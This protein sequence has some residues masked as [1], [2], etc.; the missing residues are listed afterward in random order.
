[1]ERTVDRSI[2]KHF[3]AQMDPESVSVRYRSKP[4]MRIFLISGD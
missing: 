2:N 4:H 3:C 1:M